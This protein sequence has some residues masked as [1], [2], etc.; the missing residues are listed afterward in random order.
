M[1]RK[2]LLFFM[3]TVFALQAEN[4]DITFANKALFF[5]SHQVLGPSMDLPWFTGNKRSK[6]PSV[7]PK[8][9]RCLLE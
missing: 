9:G 8:G 6:I 5:C 1:R 7:R 3:L 2:L 4:K